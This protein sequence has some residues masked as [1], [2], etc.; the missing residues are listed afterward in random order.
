MAGSVGSLDDEAAALL[1]VVAPGLVAV[2]AEAKA[3][4]SFVKRSSVMIMNLATA[5]PRHRADRR[6]TNERHDRA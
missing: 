3:L 4:N 1:A 2:L 6:D 5:T